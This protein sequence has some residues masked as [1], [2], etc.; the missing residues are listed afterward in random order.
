MNKKI[1]SLLCF[2]Y[3]LSL[4]GVKHSMADIAPSQPDCPGEWSNNPYDY[5]GTCK[6]IN[7]KV[8][9]EA[10]EK[11]SAGYEYI[12]EQGD[13]A[14]CRN[15]TYS[16]LPDAL[17]ISYDGK[18]SY[19]LLAVKKSFLEERGGLDGIFNTNIHKDPTGEYCETYTIM[20]PKNQK[21][22]DANFYELIVERNNGED[23]A[24]WGRGGAYN[25]VSDRLFPSDVYPYLVVPANSPVTDKE[26]VYR[27]FMFD[28]ESY[29]K[30]PCEIVL[31]KSKEIWTLDN[32]EKK[33][34]A[35]IPPTG[36]SREQEGREYFVDDNFRQEAYKAQDAD[37]AQVA[38]DI[39]DKEN[40]K[41]KQICAPL[42]E[43]QP[44]KGFWTKVA[45]FFKSMVGKKC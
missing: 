11:F 13:S 21:D 37:G 36:Y 26:F 24:W 16:I 23:L 10:S 9:I 7:K 22:F 30:K 1:L 6:V 14:Y 40:E 27:P 19:N 20:S 25:E 17:N 39:I 29:K 45:C 8:N 32:G 4:V 12:M 15:K 34:Y 18:A 43:K 42:I 38:Q 41:T 28:C 2:A 35:F 44:E 31:Y 5:T 33:E 3:L